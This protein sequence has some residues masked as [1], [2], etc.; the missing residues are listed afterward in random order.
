M[1]RRDLGDD[2]MYEQRLKV[3]RFFK[4]EFNK[5]LR[6]KGRVSGDGD[7]LLF[8]EVDEV[9]LN[10]VWVVFDLED[11]DGDFGVAEGVHEEGALEVGDTDG[12]G[13]ALF[14]EAFH[15][16]PGLV[17]GDVDGF[18]ALVDTVIT[19]VGPGSGVVLG[20]VDVLEGDGEVDQE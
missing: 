17:D 4:V 15:S 7:T 3:L 1:P 11:G 13:E 8:G 14:D 20:V 16:L 5:A 12:A 18:D 6:A 10:E 9:G 2:G 19:L